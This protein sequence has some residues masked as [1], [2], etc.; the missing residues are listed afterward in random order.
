MK[1]VTSALR[2]GRLY[3][4]EIPQYSFLLEDESTVGP[5][6]GQKDHVN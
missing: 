5:S 6:G 4:Q 2:I 3:P 1:V